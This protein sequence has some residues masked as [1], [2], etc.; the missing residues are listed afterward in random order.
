MSDSRKKVAEIFQRILD[1]AVPIFDCATVALYRIQDERFALNNTGVLL[2]IADDV[3]ILTASHHLRKKVHNS[4][5]L[6]VSWNDRT[7]L[8]IP[9]HDALFH[10]TE[11]D[12]RWRE[13]DVVRDV[14]AI[15]L[16]DFAA[17]EIL[18]AGRT[19]LCLRD[20]SMN[21]DRSPAVFLMFGF[22]QAWFRVEKSGPK[23]L[24]L[25]YPCAIYQGDHWAG[26]KIGYDPKVHL[27]LDFTRDAIDPIDRQPKT[28]P[29]YRGIQGVSGCGI[30]R[31]IDLNTP[32]DRWKPGKCKLVAIQHRYYEEPGYLLTTWIQYAIDRIFDDYPE[33]KSA[34]AIV[35][36]ND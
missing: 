35:Y 4:V 12:S 11:F 27:L 10:T 1:E 8:P 3:F 16:S 13:R 9:L 19:P 15:K 29:D 23:C 21:Q 22:P 14:T 2:R 31:V 32:I 24:P 20:I 25:V 26:S 7:D 36:P 5:P 6:Y 28:L 17:K 18:N 34:A 33:L 30:W